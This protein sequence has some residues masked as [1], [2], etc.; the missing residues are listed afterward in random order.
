[1]T[2]DVISPTSRFASIRSNTV[3]MALLVYFFVTL[4]KPISHMFVVTFIYV[5]PDSATWKYLVSIAIGCIGVVLIY[6]GLKKDEVKGSL[7]G[8]F[9]AMLIWD[10]WFE[11]GVH[12]FEKA[13][14]I[15]MVKDAEGTPVLLGSHVILEM[16]SIFLIFMLITTMFQK[17][18]RCRMLLWIRKTLGLREGLG[19]PTAGIKPQ[20]SRIAASEYLFVNWFMYC[21]MIFTLDPRIAG[22]H[23]MFTYVLS[24]AILV[25]SLYLLY[26]HS[27]QTE[28]GL[29][30]RYA[31][32]AG[33]V[34][35]Y[36]FE[37]TTLWGWYNEFWVRPDLYPI[38]C[39]IVLLLF[40]GIFTFLWKTPINP[41]TGKS[42]KLPRS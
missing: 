22:T 14:D 12:F 39:S 42:L 23:H 5:I 29:M 16:T 20:T 28:V 31:I 11:M 33:G 8:F 40:I 17:D 9:G 24:A 13:N 18:M 35:W 27:K 32:G 34:A 21:L 19:K 2:T 7:L 30:I 10:S 4:Q 37:I 15:P 25:W 41:E 36:N 38:S 3:F 26:K 6:K 1:M